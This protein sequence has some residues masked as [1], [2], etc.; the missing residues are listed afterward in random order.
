MLSLQLDNGLTLSPTS[1]PLDDD[2]TLPPDLTPTLPSLPWLLSQLDENTTL[3]LPSPQLSLQPDAGLTLPPSQVDDL[4]DL[5]LHP[6]SGFSSSAQTVSPSLHQQMRSS[7]PPSQDDTMMSSPIPVLLKQKIDGLD[8]DLIIRGKSKRQQVQTQRAKE[9]DDQ[10]RDSD[11]DFHGNT[12]WR[13]WR[14][15]QHNLNDIHYCDKYIIYYPTVL[16][17]I[18]LK[19][20][21]RTVVLKMES[22]NPTVLV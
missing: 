4:D 7:T 1:L 10:I 3:P 19:W 12:Q 15:G 17:A 14:G 16:Y 21:D 2:L 22:H 20:P 13:G 18:A 6:H 9:G 8:Q 5:I 11:L